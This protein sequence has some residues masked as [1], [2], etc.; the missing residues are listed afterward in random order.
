M[1]LILSAVLSFLFIFTA[2]NPSL[3]ETIFD[4]DIRII[5]SDQTGITIIYDAPRAE[6]VT[7]DGYPEKYKA[8]R[9]ARTARIAKDDAPLLPVKLIPVGVPF[10]AKPT[11]SIISQ[12]Y[13]PIAKAEVPN[14]ASEGSKEAFD[15]K[16]ASQVIQKNWPL[17]DA[18]F[19]GESVIRGLRVLKLALAAAKLQDGTLYQADQI[20]VRI[21]FNSPGT[22]RSYAARPNGQVF[23]KVMS[24]VVANFDQ[25]Q[26]WRVEWPPIPY[27]TASTQSVFDSAQVWVKISTTQGGIHKIVPYSLSSLGIDLSSYDPRQFRL[28]YGGGDELPVDND[29]ARPV[30]TEVPISISGSSDGSFDF[31]DE[32]L[33]FAETVDRPE[34]DS[35]YQ[36]IQ[37]QRNHYTYR[38]AYWLALGGDFAGSPK[39]WADVSGEPVQQFA[40]VST[41]FTE[42]SHIEQELDFYFDGFIDEPTDYYNW[43]AGNQKT[44][45]YST[46][47]QDVVP[48]SVADVFVKSKQEFDQ[49]MVNNHVVPSTNRSGEFTEYQSSDFAAGTAFNSLFLSDANPVFLDYIDVLYNR[50]LNVNNNQLAFRSPDDIGLIEYHLTEVP[51]NYLL[52]DVTAADNVSRITGAEL[53]GTNLRFQYPNT[54]QE[55]FFICTAGNYFSP[56]SVELYEP[57][58]LRATSNGADYVIITPA[59]F[60]DQSRQL[61]DFRSSRNPDLRVRVVRLQ[62]IYN[63]FSWGLDDPTAIRDF[64]KYTFENWAGAPPSYALLV[65]DGHFD[66]RNN[67]N[68]NEPNYMPPFHSVNSSSGRRPFGSDESYIYFGE[69]GILDSDNSGGLDMMIG[70]LP[71]NNTSDMDVMLNKIINYDAHPNLGKWR[72][73]VII[74]AD[75]NL[76]GSDSQNENFHTDQG[77]GLA[78]HNVPNTMEVKKIFLVN[79]PLRAGN[80]KPDAREALIQAFNDGGL[81]VDWIGHGNKGLWAHEQLFRRIEDIPRLTNID[82]LPLVFTASCSIG[83]FDYPTEQGMAEDLVRAPN[84]GSIV[85]IGATRKVYSSGNIDLNEYFFNQLLYEDSISFSQALYVAKMLREA[86]EPNDNDRKF[87]YFGDPALIAGKPILKTL[88]TYRPDSLKGLTVDSIAGYV[89]NSEGDV[90]TDFNGRVWVL[91]KDASVRERV[92]EIHY[93]G[94]PNGYYNDI[95][96]PGPT[97]FNGPAAVTNGYFSSSFFIPKDITYGGT[98]AKIFVYFENGAIDGSG[99]VDSLPMAGGVSAEADSIG[100]TIEVVY[101]DRTLDANSMESLPSNAALQVNLFDPHGINI[102]GTMGH[103]ITVELDNGETNSM[104]ITNNFNFDDGQ[105]QSGTANFQLPELSEGEHLLTVKSWDNYNNS[106][107]FSTYIQIYASDEFFVSDV[108]NYPNPAVEID[109]TVFQYML[110]NNADRVTLKIFTLTGRKIRSF[111]LTSPEYTTSGFHYLPYDLRDSDGDRIASGVYIYRLEATGVGFDGRRRKSDFQSKLALIR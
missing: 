39:R 109:S 40:L 96:W 5:K 73:T 80:S 105:W 59:I 22:S 11:I 15:A 86:G 72:N 67:W 106:S 18:Y 83:Y 89:T 90:Q 21:D 9:I 30:L 3:A 61:A 33:F 69:F 8:P 71:A 27:K 7:P 16:I 65:G 50:L 77:E 45:N 62:D 107:L 53:T 56:T 84:G 44:F 2:L 108:M 28:F 51:A 20:T 111:D 1:K 38:N 47:L 79:Y 29:V 54:G 43:W 10:N 23:D 78:N 85:S 100:P 57:D 34:Y 95:I 46:Q 75:D 37:M 17:Q 68:N 13:S 97:I 70:R 48:G 76:S 42:L 52:L 4:N 101:N 81:V 66:Y 63:Q 87:M 98:G 102:T 6:L 55:K 60:Y 82:K 12:S 32:L 92:Y 94:N 24:K 41:S 99:V 91:V 103:A 19:E 64:L 49:L 74:A 104:D 35:T 14:Y 26:N 31:G 36:R 88:F 25:S 110:S 93:D 58:D